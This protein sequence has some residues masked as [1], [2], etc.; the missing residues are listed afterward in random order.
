MIHSLINDY[1]IRVKNAAKA[2]RSTMVAPSSKLVENVTE[3]MKRNGFITD[4]TVD[5][6][7]P[8]TITIT[9]REVNDVKLFSTPGRK[10]YSKVSQ[11]PWGKTKSS[12]IIVSTSAGIMSQ[13][14][15]VAKNIGGQLIAEIS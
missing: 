13:R 11:L 6:E 7:V 4:Y 14:E 9:I 2:G 12:L 15:A 10:L 5:K 3:V 8:R 1:L